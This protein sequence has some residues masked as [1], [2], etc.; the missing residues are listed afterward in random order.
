MPWFRRVKQKFGIVPG[1]KR[2]IPDGVWL[3]CERCGEIL[4][5]K[6]LEKNLWICSKCR[7]HFRISSRDYVALLLDGGDF[8]EMDA[9]LLPTDPLRFAGYEEKIKD[10]QKKTQ[11]KEAVICGEGRIGGHDVVI[12]VMDFRFVGGSMGSVVGEKVKRAVLRAME[13]RVP[14]VIV[15]TSG[16]A[17]MQEG[18]LSLMQMTKT[19]AALSELSRERVPFVSIL[20]DPTYAGVMASYASLG[21]V[22]VSEPGALIGFAGRRVIEQTIGEELPPEFQRSEFM[23]KHGMVDMVVER[24][25]LKKTLVRLLEFFSC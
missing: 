15:S 5:R 14:L 6:G 8:K 18:I 11:L 22:I 3:K 20:T 1:E 9:T 21:D 24:R 23:L 25:D 19:A 17:R 7:F 12:S 16:G 4:Y 2:E 10:S 13:R